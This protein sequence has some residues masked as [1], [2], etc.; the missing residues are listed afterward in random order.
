M[1]W[2]VLGHSVRLVYEFP[3]YPDCAESCLAS[4]TI[5]YRECKDEYEDGYCCPGATSL[6]AKQVNHFDVWSC[7]AR[8]CRQALSDDT[9]EDPAQLAAELFMRQ[10]AAVGRPLW[11]NF[12]VELPS[13]NLVTGDRFPSDYTYK[14]FGGFF[15]HIPWLSG[16]QTP[17]N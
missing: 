9:A 4:R 12:T 14:D 10:C 3:G 15:L 5:G 17:D 16:F 13:T 7:I 6:A 8:Q 2:D 1:R 11:S